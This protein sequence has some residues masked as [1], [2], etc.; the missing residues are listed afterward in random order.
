MAPRPPPSESVGYTPPRV[1]RPPPR[2][3]P[4]EQRFRK[5]HPRVR[6]PPMHKLSKEPPPE[7]TAYVKQCLLAVER[8]TNTCRLQPEE[9]AATTARQHAAA[10]IKE[11]LMAQARALETE[12]LR[13]QK[14][15]GNTAAPKTIWQRTGVHRGE[16]EAEINRRRRNVELDNVR[17][18]LQ[19]LEGLGA[20]PAR[21]GGR[22]GWRQR[23]HLG[24]SF[25]LSSGR[26]LGGNRAKRSRIPRFQRRMPR[27][28]F[29]VPRSG[30]Q[31]GIIGPS[32][33][34]NR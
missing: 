3:H 18:D 31:T 28:T 8:L 9:E 10:A 5:L 16:T 26:F 20:Q 15:A 17:S 32:R 11:E 12:L 27:S 25:P 13:E 14:L 23:A 29:V 19:V 34:S 4:P 24:L 21:L 22:R 6:S 33:A 30:Q 2:A 7:V 1:R